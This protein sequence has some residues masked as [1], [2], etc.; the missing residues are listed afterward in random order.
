MIFGADHIPR[1]TIAV[2]PPL[3]GETAIMILL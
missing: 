1:K 3:T 2:F